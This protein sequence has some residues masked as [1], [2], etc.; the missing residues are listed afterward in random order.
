MQRVKRVLFIDDEREILDLA[1]D[2]LSSPGV[3]LDV[4]ENLK[5]AIQKLIAHSY[6]VLVTD[7]L[8]PGEKGVDFLLWVTEKCPDLPVI[9]FTGDDRCEESLKAVENRLEG[10]LHKPES[11]GE[12]CD[13]VRSLLEDSSSSTHDLN[14]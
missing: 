8:F 3:S 4:A 10:V 1:E 7:F 12:L 2:W 14:K 6:D 9:V 11:L 13:R 5:E